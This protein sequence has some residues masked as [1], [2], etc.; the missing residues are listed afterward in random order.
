MHTQEDWRARGIIPAIIVIGIGVLLLLRNMDIVV[1]HDLWRYWPVILIAVGLVKM[2]DAQH[3]GTQVTGGIMVV[4]GAL[5]LANTLELVRISWHD[6]WPLILIGAG[7]LMLYTRLATPR[8]PATAADIDGS[9]NEY[10][11]FG[12]VSRKLTTDDF[13]GGYASAMFGGIEI[14]LRRASMRADSA[15]IDVSAIFG[16]VEFKMPQNWIVIT[17]VAAIF[18]GVDNKCVQPD[19]DVPGVK[20]IYVKGSAMFGGIEFKN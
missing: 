3:T 15:T 18:G 4:A 12:G 9:L 16:G 17:Q 2:V 6:F 10:A 1:I 13:R 7:I 8:A 19:A 20:R 14:D 5:F 11:I